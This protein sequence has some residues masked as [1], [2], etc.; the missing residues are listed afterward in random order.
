MLLV[1]GIEKYIFYHVGAFFPSRARQVETI[2]SWTYEFYM[3]TVCVS[4]AVYSSL[5]I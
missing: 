1:S 4:V 2:G 5:T 3:S